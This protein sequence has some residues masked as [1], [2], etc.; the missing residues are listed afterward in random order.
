MARQKK[1]TSSFEHEGEEQAQ[2][3]ELGDASD[4]DT[5]QDIQDLFLNSDAKPKQSKGAL[6]VATKR[7]M[8]MQKQMTAAT[9]MPT[10]NGRPPLPAPRQLPGHLW[11][12]SRLPPC[13]RPR[14]VV[15]RSTAQTAP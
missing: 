10:L 7:A 12:P 11:S 1:M 15:R 4:K 3:R 13:R 5:K 2:S 9:P 6:S 14:L 8:A